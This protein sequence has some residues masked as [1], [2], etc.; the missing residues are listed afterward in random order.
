MNSGL[1]F[2]NKQDF[3]L[4]Q[5]KNGMLLTNNIPGV[6]LLLFYSPRCPN[7]NAFLPIFKKLPTTINGCSFAIVNLTKNRELIGMSQ[8]SISP[9]EYVPFIIMYVNGKP[10]M[11]Y[12]GPHREEA[13]TSFVVEVANKLP[14]T[15]KRTVC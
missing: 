1:L 5:G 9:I 7:S 3:N 11:I 14:K 15:I 4:S 6:S 13:I 2:L 8:R 12:N 10:Y